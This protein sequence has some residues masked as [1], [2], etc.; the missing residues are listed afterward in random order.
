MGFCDQKNVWLVGHH[1][2]IFNQ[3]HLRAYAIHITL[4]SNGGFGKV[5]VENVCVLVSLVLLGTS[6]TSCDVLFRRCVNQRGWGV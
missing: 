3:F 4:D 2:G 1:N 6:T 5:L